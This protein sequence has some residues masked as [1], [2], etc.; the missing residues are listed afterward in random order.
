[1]AN[2]PGTIYSP[3][4][5]ENKSGVVY[6][7]T[8][9]TVIYADDI[10]KDDDEIVAIETELG[11]NPKGVFAS[12]GAYLASLA[13][14]IE[15]IIASL[16][17]YL[18]SIVE[19]TTPQLGGELDCQAH[20]IGFTQQT[21]F[22]DGATTIDWKLG[23]KFYFTFDIYNE[24]FT[25][26]PPTKPCNLILVLK[27]APTGGQTVTWPETVFFPGGL[28]PVLST[29]NDAVDLVSFYFDGTNYFGNSSLAFSHPV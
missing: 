25:F 14:S 28:A 10:T 11:V 22:G 20:S 21:A 16:A 8:K 23:N 18:T 7:P 24:V 12:V 3:R 19:D 4:E 9:K 29:A 1:M 15:D 6:D 5:K 26:V 17:D 27:Q 13:G 2:Y